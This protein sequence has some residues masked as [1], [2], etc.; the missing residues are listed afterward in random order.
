MAIPCNPK[1][2][3]RN[4]AEGFVPFTQAT[5]KQHKPAELKTISVNLRLV[6]REIRS[7]VV[8]VDDTKTVQYR[9]Q[10]LQRSNNALM[11]IRSYAKRH[12]I[13]V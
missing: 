8:S 4:I 9:N 10:L 2:Y 1:Q 6:I 5:C 11:L 12:R 3:A 7:Q 13:A